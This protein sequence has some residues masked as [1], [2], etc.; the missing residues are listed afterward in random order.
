MSEDDAT[1][2]DDATSENDAPVS[3]L[4][5]PFV[6]YVE[7]SQTAAET[8]R[9]ALERSL[10]TQ[11]AAVDGWA[12][13][14]A[15][16]AD[17]Q[18]TEAT[19]SQE[20]AW[21][22]DIWSETLQNALVHLDDA[23]DEEGIDL[24]SLQLIWLHALDDAITDVGKRPTFGATMTESV[25]RALTAQY[26]GDQ[27]RRSVL[28]SVDVPT[29]RDIEAVGKRLLDLEYRQKSVEDKLD[30]VLAAVGADS[31]TDPERTVG[32]EPAGGAE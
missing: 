27:L 28:G 18:P 6:W 11:Q 8:S 5:A 24:D 31:D 3:P 30:A 2:G 23:V 17:E 9:T 15:P 13:T 14:F 19:P 32:S 10:E 16:Q 7:T 12:S 22:Y 1:S 25:E 29:D 4:T 20:M 26:W 21:L